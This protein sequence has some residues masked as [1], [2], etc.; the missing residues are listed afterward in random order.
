[1][2]MPELIDAFVSH[3]EGLARRKDRGAIAKLRRGTGRTAGSA[4]DALPLIVPF[5]PSDDRA[6]ESFFLVGALFG[7]HP[8]P[9]GTGNFGDAFRRLGD[10]ESAK[11]R[12]LA[13]LNAHADDVGEHLRHAVS[14]ARAK[15]V[16]ID[17]RRLLRDLTHWSHPERFVQLAWARSYWGRAAGAD[18]TAPSSSAAHTADKEA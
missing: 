9:G 15:D 3:L 16:P 12:F 10:H 18:E 17:Y 5:L 11:K 7:M 14:L 8:E 13:L 2:G 6:A 1:M 4:V